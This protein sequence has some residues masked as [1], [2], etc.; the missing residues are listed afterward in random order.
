MKDGT[1]TQAGKYNE[2]LDSGT[3]F[4][5][6]VGA[7][8][9]A[10]AAVDSFEKGSATSQSTTSRENKVSDDEDNKQEEHL[11]A[12]PKGQ[13]VQ[14]EE[15]EKGEVGF[16]V[17]QKYMSLAYGGALVPVIL[18]VQ[19]LFQILNIGSNYWMAWVTP[20]SKDVK[21]PVSGSTLIIVYVVLATA[22]SVCILVRAMLA[23][24][25]GFKIA[26]ELFNQMHLR[27]FRA[28]MSFFDATPIGRILNRVRTIIYYLLIQT[29]FL[30]TVVSHFLGFNR[31]KCRGFEITKS[32]FESSCYRYKH[33]GNYRSDGTGCLAGP[34]CLHPCHRCMHLVSGILLHNTHKLRSNLSFIT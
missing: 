13:L 20:V 32:I 19:S 27:V 21:P 8:T 4:M 22:S 17:Y 18:V 23:A 5:E 1:I 33:F 16:S 11:G 7:H 6:L 14:E 34:Y 9:D 2:I 3:D 25:T 29:P 26:T 15:R 30:I 31:P 24:M 12:T 28:S 10:L